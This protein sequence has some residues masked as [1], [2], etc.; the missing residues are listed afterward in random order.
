MSIIK[1]LAIDLG[2]STFHAVGR[3]RNEQEVFRKK[4]NRKSLVTYLNN[5]PA[6]T[7]ACEA[8]SGAHWLARQCLSFGHEVKLIPPQFVKPYV[9]TNKNDFI[10]AEAI[11]E[12]SSRPNMRFVSVKTEMEQVVAVIHRIRQGY[13]KERTACM[14]RIGSVLVEFGLSLPVGHRIMKRLFQW[15][16]QQTISLP[17][18]LLRE[19]SELHEYYLYLNSRIDAQDDKLKEWLNEHEQG[20]LIRT[21]PGIGHMTASLLL[22]HVRQA[23]EF[24]SGRNMAAWLG[25]VPRQYSTGGKNRLLGISKRGNKTLRTFFIHGA[26]AVLSRLELARQYFGD[27]VIKL[28]SSKPYNVA[29]VALANKLVRI[30]WAVLV[31]QRPFSPQHLTPN[32]Q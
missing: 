7:I 3:D 14:N 31:K 2:K 1:I 11:A 15:L 17:P 4:F 12:A 28:R 19:L 30:A 22:A 23:H 29:V 13:I 10:D 25:L 26:R 18:L 9:K 24:K 8:C 21:I 5:L 20:N 32:L 6:C 16:A 27:W